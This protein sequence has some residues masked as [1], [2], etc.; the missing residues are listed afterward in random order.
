MIRAA[1]LFLSA[2]LLPL[3]PATAQLPSS[4]RERIQRDELVSLTQRLIGIRSDYDEGVLANHSEMAAFLADYLRELGM[5]VD[6]V[7][8]TPGYPT[9][10]G[11]LRDAI[12]PS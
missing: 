5:D 10:A 1:F 3:V 2:W 12:G 6:V 4:V 7:E 9:V 8:P 11:R